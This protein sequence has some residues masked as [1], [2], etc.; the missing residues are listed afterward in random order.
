MH[1][2]PTTKR[3]R[4]GVNGN[5]RSK[6][7]PPIYAKATSV[8]QKAPGRRLRNENKENYPSGDAPF[9]TAKKNL[10]N[11]LCIKLIKQCI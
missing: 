7:A 3:T 2:K 11:N 10:V 6:E 1:L 4:K 5:C 9:I 8:Q